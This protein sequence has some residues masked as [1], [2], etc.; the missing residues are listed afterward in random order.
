MMTA[1]KD[2]LKVLRTK[3]D[4]TQE[5]LAKRAGLSAKSIGLYES[6]VENL[7]KSNYQ[8]LEKLAKALGVS[9]DDIFLG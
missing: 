8:T 6:N 5:E 4:L 9:V 2:K 3:A 7:R 1:T